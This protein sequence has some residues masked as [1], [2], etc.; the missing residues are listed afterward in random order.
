MAR[1][2]ANLAKRE[3]IVVPRI[4]FY[5]V[6]TLG[7]LW[8]G[9]RIWVEPAWI[10][11]QL[12]SPDGEK[13]A[14]LKRSVYVRHHFVVEIK[15]GWTWQTAYYSPPLPDDLRMDLGE[16]LRWS[17]DAKQVYLTF[18]GEPVWGYDFPAQRALT[19]PGQT[20]FSFIE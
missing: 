1:T 17:D 7:V 8:F 9:S 19:F 3:G 11:Q 14:R 2:Y 6:V 13:S 12:D 20:N 10:V 16:R 15:D 5:A 4:V 18:K